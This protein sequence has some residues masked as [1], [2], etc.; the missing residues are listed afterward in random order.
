MTSCT[1][2]RSTNGESRAARRAPGARAAGDRARR[3]GA[4]DGPGQAVRAGRTAR[5]R[6][7][8]RARRPVCADLR[9]PA[10]RR[11]DGGAARAVAERRRRQDRPDR[12]GS[13]EGP[14]PVPPRLPGERAR[15][16]LRLPPL[17]A[18]ADGRTHAGRLRAR[19][20]RSRSPRQARAPVLAVLRLQRLEQPARGRLGDDPAGLRRLER[21]AGAETDARR[22][23]LQPARGRREGGVGRRQARARRRHASRRASGLR[24]ARELLRRGALSGELGRAGRRLRRHARAHH[25]RTPGRANDP[26]RPGPGAAG[27]PVD[28]VPGPLGRAA[29]QLLQR[30]D[31]A[32]SEDPVDGADRVVG[33]L[34]HPQ[35]HR[36]R[37]ECVRARCHRFLL[38]RSRRGFESAGAA[39]R[40]PLEFG[41]LLAGLV[42]LAI[43]LLSRVTWRPSAPLRVAR[44]RAWGQILAAAARMYLARFPL[45]VGIGVVFVPIALLVSLLQALVLHAT[46]VL[47]VQTP[48]RATDWSRS[49]CS[50]SEPR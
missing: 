31:G 20:D 42:L 49:S 24:L 23:R 39:G 40:P 9:R 43:I 36:P 46:N 14:L 26:E 17:A 34:A 22:D 15:P 16:G 3:P 18:A 45:F 7:G 19:R 12:R 1:S 47:G 44:R 29:P 8:L 2:P 33:R 21:G 13:L 27:V 32:Q 6:H 35:L 41:L 4:G 48:A 5:R 37:R 50:P 25:R 28:R 11:A 38:Q 30:T 10:L